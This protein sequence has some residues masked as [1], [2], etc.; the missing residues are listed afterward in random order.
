MYVY[1]SDRKSLIRCRCSSDHS[2][3]ASASDIKDSCSSSNSVS[4][5]VERAARLAANRATSSKADPSADERGT[6][7]GGCS[8]SRKLR[9]AVMAVSMS[10]RVVRSGWTGRL[11]A[12]APTRLFLRASGLV[13]RKLWTGVLGEEACSEAGPSEV[14]RYSQVAMDSGR[15]GGL[16]GGARGAGGRKR[17]E[18]E[19]V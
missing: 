9:R 7:M 14:S 12:L 5:G 16:G 10:W 17:L 18:V 15:G 6:G 11:D 3:P 8:R 4:A 13:N 2:G 1:D 19:G